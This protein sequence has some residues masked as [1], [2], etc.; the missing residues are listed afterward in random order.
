M[1]ART[2]A[3]THKALAPGVQVEVGVGTLAGSTI[4]L[5]SIAW[6]GSLIVGR[7]DIGPDGTAQDK[8][9]TR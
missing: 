9:L 2:H 3:L 4:M 1:H 6:G 7:C 5:L 8:T